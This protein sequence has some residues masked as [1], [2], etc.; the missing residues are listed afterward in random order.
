MT[1]NV[2][3]DAG[4]FLNFFFFFVEWLTDHTQSSYKKLKNWSY[5]KFM[6]LYLKSSEDN[7]EVTIPK[8]TS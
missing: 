5:V 1:S 7:S 3:L 4:P 6:F 2:N 8:N